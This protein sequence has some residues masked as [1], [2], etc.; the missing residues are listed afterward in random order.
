MYKRQPRS[1]SGRGSWAV[2]SP[3]AA[4][5]ELESSLEFCE[6]WKHLGDGH[7]A[8]RGLGVASSV[9][10]VPPCDLDVYKRQRYDSERMRI[11]RYPLEAA[12]ADGNVKRTS[13]NLEPVAGHKHRLREVGGL[14][15]KSATDRL[16]PSGQDAGG[17]RYGAEFVAAG[18]VVT[19]QLP[20]G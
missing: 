7:C 3:S 12:I 16:L 14:S 13:L 8:A 2:R 1:T 9:P 17:L 20:V 5:L 6:H 11:E 15:G 18:R 19:P 10:A 4:P